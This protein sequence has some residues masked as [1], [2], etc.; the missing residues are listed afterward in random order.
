MIEEIDEWSIHLWEYYSEILKRG[1]PF[2][3]AAD[4]NLINKIAQNLQL[5]SDANPLSAFH[6]SCNGCFTI[7]KSGARVRSDIYKR[8][9]YG[10]SR[11][12]CLAVQ[13]VLVVE[14]LLGDTEYSELEYFP[15]YRRR[16][17]VLGGIENANPLKHDFERIWLVLSEELGRAA[18][19]ATFI[20]TFARGGSRKNQTTNYPLSQALFTTEDLLRIQKET[21]NAISPSTLNKTVFQA[22]R[23]ISRST[24]LG[25]RARNLILKCNNEDTE[26]ALCEQVKSFATSLALGNKKKRSAIRSDD[27]IFLAERNE[28][29]FLSDDSFEIYMEDGNGK[30]SDLDILEELNCYFEDF[31]ALFLAFR[32]YQYSQITVAEP[33]KEETKAIVVIPAHSSF[34]FQEAYKQHYDISPVI[35][36]S[37]V[38]PGYIVFF[39]SKLDKR[40]CLKFGAPVS[41]QP[42]KSQIEL[43]GGI[44]IDSRSDTYLA[45]YPPTS[46]S[47]QGLPLSSETIVTV[48]GDELRAQEFFL[49]LGEVHDYKSFSVMVKSNSIQ[50]ALT[51]KP[52]VKPQY[53]DAGFRLE[54]TELEPFVDSLSED[55]VGLR[56]TVI[57]AGK[58]GVEDKS[59]DTSDLLQVLSQSTL[60]GLIRPG[61]KFRISDEARQALTPLLK[62]LSHQFPIANLAAGQIEQSKLIVFNGLTRQLLAKLEIIPRLKE[63]LPNSL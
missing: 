31:A 5:S 4:S 62:Q 60:V 17:G 41:K 43:L 19:P 15:R 9:E 32:N 54:G 57:A 30:P 11:T 51:S 63:D 55:E 2:Y 52:L 14:E 49:R 21:Q 10:F 7:S 1:Q 47:Y 37:N 25:R 24:F 42:S 50:F 3:L 16:I 12:I 26:V 61:R 28:E 45:G 8:K 6:K 53:F 20:K 23:N 48:N 13:Q 35:S 58:L 22:L 27:Y 34:A 44:K 33:L 36:A 40:I 46:F 59:Y 18:A 39:C 29:D 56:G 38:G